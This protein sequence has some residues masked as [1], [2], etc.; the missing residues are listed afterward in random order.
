MRARGDTIRAML[1]VAAVFG[2][3]QYFGGSAGVQIFLFAAVMFLLYEVW[4]LEDR[5][6]KLEGP[7]M[8]KLQRSD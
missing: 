4:N 2:I 7:P 6:R 5:V 3:V 1:L 8:V